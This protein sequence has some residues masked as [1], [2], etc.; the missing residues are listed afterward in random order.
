MKSS[1]V[2]DMA[3]VQE[4]DTILWSVR[5]DGQLLGFTYQAEQEVYAWHR[6]TL[7]GYSDVGKTAA[8]V[9]ESVLS[10]PSPDGSQNELW[11]IVKRYVDGGTKRFIEYL[12][13]R[14]VPESAVSGAV[15][16]DAGLSYSGSAVSSISGLWHL[17]GETVAILAD[18]RVHPNV[19]VDN[20]GRVTLNYAASIVQIGFPMRARWQSMRLETLTQTGTAQGKRKVVNEVAVRVIEASNFEYGANFSNLIRNEFTTDQSALDTALALFSGDVTGTVFYARD[21]VGP[22]KLSF[23][24]AANHG[25]GMAF[26][27]GLYVYFFFNIDL[28]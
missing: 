6:H 3:W 1:P 19:V 17:R 25:T 9:V 10:I 11:M 26:G 24:R 16:S 2:V 8:P 7:G 18:G 20:A 28:W 12:R 27:S 5:A 23:S 13:P 15:M 4:P 14:W 22:G 21:Y